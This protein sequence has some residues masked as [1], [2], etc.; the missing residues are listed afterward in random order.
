MKRG[1]LT[2]E[3]LAGGAHSMV[4]A[5]CGNEQRATR[6]AAGARG[7]KE[8][9]PDLAPHALLA[10]VLQVQICTGEAGD[11]PMAEARYHTPSTPC[12]ILA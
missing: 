11:L 3:M 7:V 8:G 1:G 4:V 12:R 6:S 10:F 2:E 5:I 9:P